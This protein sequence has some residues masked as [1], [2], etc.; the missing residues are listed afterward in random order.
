MPENK[1]EK[2]DEEIK[3]IEEKK[4]E[5]TDEQMDAVTGGAAGTL[6]TTK[7]YTPVS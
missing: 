2:K 5:L 7:I 6:S 1:V 3:S 4:I